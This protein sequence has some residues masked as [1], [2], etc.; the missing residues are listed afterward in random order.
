MEAFWKFWTVLFLIQGSE[1]LVSQPNP[2]LQMCCFPFRPFLKKLD[3]Y[4][5]N[6]LSLNFEEEKKTS[7]FWIFGTILVLKRKS[8]SLVLQL[9]PPL[10]SNDFLKKEN[11]MEKFKPIVAEKRQFE[12]RHR[13]KLKSFPVFFRLSIAFFPKCVEF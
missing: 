7:F 11:L 13:T 4:Y 6:Y 2:S 8:N 1:L 9:V 3:L 10:R 5:R 12:E